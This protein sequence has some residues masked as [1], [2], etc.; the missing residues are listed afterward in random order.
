V[1]LEEFVYPRHAGPLAEAYGGGFESVFV[2]LHPFVRVPQSLSWSVTRAYPDDAQIA[3]VGV[4]CTW[5]EVAAKTGINCSARMNQALLTSIGSLADPVADPAGRDGLQRFL[6]TNPVW[7]PVEGRFEPLLQ[8]DLLQIFAM[9]GIDELV[10]IP[11]FPQSDPVVR[12]AVDGLA[13]GTIPFP[14]CGTLLAREASI[15]F[16]VDWDSF[17]T[18]FYGK[19]SFIADAARKLKLEGFFATATTDH[20]WWNY[21]M[22]CATVTVSPED[23]QENESRRL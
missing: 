7:M 22:G 12:L 1:K 23:W 11:E 6:E 4:K 13:D 3:S 9:S 20:A 14:G 19:R 17:F 8:R 18:L 15:L 21:S 16:T 2:L 5:S 10:Y